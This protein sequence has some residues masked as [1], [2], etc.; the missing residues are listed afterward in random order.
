MKPDWQDTLTP[1]TG[2]SIQQLVMLLVDELAIGC[3]LTDSWTNQVYTLIYSRTWFHNCGGDSTDS[4]MLI[5]AVDVYNSR[6]AIAAWALVLKPDRILRHRSP[7]F[8]LRIMMCFAIATLT[9]FLVLG[10]VM[11]EEFIIDTPYVFVTPVAK[12]GEK[13]Q[14]NS[15]LF[16][17]SIGGV[18]QCVP[19]EIVWQ[20]GTGESYSH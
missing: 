17:N 11:A 20:G 4:I 6:K 15:S 10:L 1:T 13:P 16:I 3:E 9:T 2:R 14:V 18:L 8:D 5:Q 19:I 7:S 12:K